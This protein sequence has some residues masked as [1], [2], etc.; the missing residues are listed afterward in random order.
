M[1]LIVLG[2]TKEEI[3]DRQHE[4]YQFCLYEQFVILRL[5][6]QDGWIGS[7]RELN[8]TFAQAIA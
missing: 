8:I 5:C 3:N 7:Q 4:H 2:Q 6:G 1:S